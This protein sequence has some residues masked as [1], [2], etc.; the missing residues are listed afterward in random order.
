M[1]YMFH[2]IPKC[3][4]TSFNRFLD[5]VFNVTMDYHNAGG[6][7]ANPALFERY[8]TNPVDLLALNEND[9]ICGHFNLEGI[10]LHQRY[11]HL[12]KL[13][14]RKFSVIR[15]PFETAKSGVYFNVKRGVFDAMSPD[16]IGKKIL[17]RANIMAKTLG[18]TSVGEIDKVLDRYWFIAPLDQIETAARIIEQVTKRSGKSVEHVN[19]T[20]KPDHSLDEKLEAKFRERSSLDCAIYERACARFGSFVQNLRPTDEDFSLFR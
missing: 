3:G 19:T 12:E 17:G 1:F 14:H 13:Q 15:E 5:S 9:C 2:H 6:P 18:I 8:L 20:Q 11:P 4:G 7:K 16:A 10:F